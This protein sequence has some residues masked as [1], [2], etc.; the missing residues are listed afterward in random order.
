M[1]AVFSLC[2]LRNVAMKSLISKSSF[3]F[4]IITSNNHCPRFT[5]SRLCVANRSKLTT[6]TCEIT[7]TPNT[8]NL[9]ISPPFPRRMKNRNTDN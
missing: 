6:P 3:A 8:V 9:L 7:V 4:A 2:I 1:C 5:H